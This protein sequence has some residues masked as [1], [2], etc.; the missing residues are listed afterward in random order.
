MSWRDLVIGR[1]GESL[2]GE[3]LDASFAITTVFGQ[4]LTFKTRDLCWIHF[5]NPQ[6]VPEDEIWTVN[7][8]CVRGALQGTAVRFRP[9]GQKPISIPHSAIHTLLVNQSFAAGPGLEP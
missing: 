1:H 7:D 3:V 4:P 8:D 6:E 9:A 2:G 5:K